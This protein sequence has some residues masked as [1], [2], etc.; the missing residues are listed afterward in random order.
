MVFL[1]KRRYGRW[2][3]ILKAAAAEA[4]SK[5]TN[6]SNDDEIEEDEEESDI[7]DGCKEKKTNDASSVS[8]PNKPK[9][10]GKSAKAKRAAKKYAEQDDKDRELA[11]KLLTMK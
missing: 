2:W 1:L 3:W 6:I 11:I 7:D 4:E 8:N 9:V 10:R 5:E